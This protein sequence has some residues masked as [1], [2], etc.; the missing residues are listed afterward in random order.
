MGGLRDG[1]VDLEKTA[2]QLRVDYLVDTR[3]P[4]VPWEN[5]P[6]T[7]KNNWRILAGGFPATELFE[8]FDITKKNKGGRYR[9]RPQIQPGGVPK[10]RTIQEN[11]VRSPQA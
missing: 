1:L 3:R 4:L 6:E 10:G 7:T 11:V 2:K 8:M 5:L 9:G